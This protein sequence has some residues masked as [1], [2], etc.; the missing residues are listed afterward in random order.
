MD[1]FVALS[2]AAAATRRLKLGTGVCL[3]NQRD[4]IQTA[5]L[6][7][8]LDQLSGGRFLFGIGIGWNAEEMANHGT[9]FASRAKLVRER[10]EAMQ[11]IWT[12]EKAEY[13]GSLVDFDPVFAWPKPVQRPYPPIIVGGGFPQGARRA[14]RYGNGWIPIIG[15]APMQEALAAFRALAKE[16]GRDPAEVPITAFAAPEDL[17]EIQHLA[18]LGVTRVVVALDSEPAET[19]LPQ[20]DRWAALIRAAG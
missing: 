10:V 18:A 3:V 19:I 4:P 15:R 2:F 17:R 12:E 16:V 9:A 8:S 1:P 13:H 6:V 11:T 14:L 5:K 20:L 7:A